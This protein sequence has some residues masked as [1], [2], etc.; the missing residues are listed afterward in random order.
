MQLSFQQSDIMFKHLS[1]SYIPVIL[2]EV[3]F[4]GF[5]D[6]EVRWGFP[7]GRS[8]AEAAE[9]IMEAFPQP[10]HVMHLKQS[11]G[12]GLNTQQ[13]QDTLEF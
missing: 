1:A 12:L 2:S 13:S 4:S 9:M 10:M 5:G 11:I 8:E 7:H 3:I 6:G